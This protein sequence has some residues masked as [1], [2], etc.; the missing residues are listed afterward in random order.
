MGTNGYQMVMDHYV[1]TKRSFTIVISPF[2]I[3][4]ILQWKEV[5]GKLHQTY[6]KAYIWPISEN[7]NDPMWAMI[8]FVTLT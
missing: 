2:T 8:R 6:F 7:F 4:E 5:I 3:E 1:Y